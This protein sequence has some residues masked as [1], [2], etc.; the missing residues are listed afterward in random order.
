MIYREDEE[1]KK[2]REKLRQLKKYAL[3]GTAA[4]TGGVLVGV[5]GGLAAPLVGVSLGA[6]LGSLDFERFTIFNEH[7]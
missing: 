6:L 3:I 1:V 4:I 5:T 7:R 2:K